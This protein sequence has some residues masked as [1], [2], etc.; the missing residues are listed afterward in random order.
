MDGSVRGAGGGKSAG[1]QAAPYEEPD[2]LHSIA[3]SHVLLAAGEGELGGL[4]NGLKSVYLDGTVLQNDDNTFNFLNVQVDSRVGT[5]NQDYIKGYPE[6]ESETA[7]G[8]ELKYGT[9][10]THAITDLDLSAISIRIST[11]TMTEVDTKTGDIY[12]TEIDFSFE[13]QTDGGS[14]IDIHDGYFQGKTTTDFQRDYRFDLPDATSGWVIRVT[15]TTPQST[16][17]SLTNQSFID[18]YTE[19][20]DAKL[21]Y[22]NTALLGILCDA[23]QFQSIPVI[24]ANWYGRIIRIPSNYN[25]YTRQYTGV[26][27]GTFV[28][29][30]TNNPAWH[31]YDICT[32]NRFGLGA[33]ITDDQVDKWSLYSIAQYC[34]GYVPTGVPKRAYVTTAGVFSATAPNLYKRGSGSFL[35]DGFQVGDEI[36][37]TGFVAAGNNGRGVITAVT[38]TQIT[39]GIDHV[40]TT[41]AA[42]GGCTIST[43]DF[44]E[45]RF[46]SALYLQAQDDAYKVLQDMASIFRG[47][48]YWAGGAIVPVCDQ[49]SDPVYTYANASVIGGKFTYSGSARKA[50]NTVA[51]VTWID[52]ANFYAATVEYVQLDDAV[53][54]F[55][56]RTTQITALGCTSRGMAQRVGR[57]LLLAEWLL[58]N[59]VSFSIGLE[60]TFCMPGQIVRV[61]DAKRAGRRIGGRIHKYADGEYVGIRYTE[62]GSIRLTEDGDVRI[63]EGDGSSFDNI[64]VDMMPGVVPSPGDTLVIMQAS[65]AATTRTITAVA[66]KTI[67]F[68]PP[69]DAYPADDAIWAVESSTLATQLFR[70]V[71]VAE[72]DGIQFDIT[73]LQHDP[74]LYAQVEAGTI[75]Q[76]PPISALPSPVQLPVSAVNLTSFQRAA[77]TA[78]ETVVRAEWA[79]PA[80]A[81]SY[82]WQWQRNGGPWSPAQKQQATSCEITAAFAGSYTFRVTTI[83]SSG[84]QSGS[85]KSSPLVVSLVTLPPLNATPVQLVIDSNGVATPDLSGGNDQ[86]TLALDANAT[87]GAPINCPQSC[88]ILVTVIQG[89]GFVLGM[90]P[91]YQPAN[92]IPY[93]AT[94]TAGAQDIVG[95]T[96]SNAGASWTYKFDKQPV[97]SAGAAF[98]IA[99]SNYTPSGY[100]V[101]AGSPITVDAT[102][103]ATINGGVMPIVS[104]GWS[105]A[106][107]GSSLLTNTGVSPTCTLSRTAQRT[108][109][110]EHWRFRAVDSTGAVAM[111][112]ATFNITIDDGTGYHG[113]PGG[114]GH[115]PG[116]EVP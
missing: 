52:P 6:V 76:Q 13:L 69:L 16:S 23:T 61:A 58:T 54:R 116:G 113:S 8:V 102:S 10:W 94:A 91:C 48:S 55:G 22:P 89:G 29:G 60:G 4:V 110:T 92:N 57:Y 3:Y 72:G 30:W 78:S 103:V 28:T 90:D 114:G 77:A 24:S 35:T 14:F 42:I 65:G 87:L 84:K 26:W 44:T 74:T 59:T 40:L 93:S 51:L 73:A 105:Y 41:A 12:G 18:A 47:I 1:G 33:R 7:V 75:T 80:G 67:A 109:I 111:A 70:V 21:R 107:S 32:Q 31:Y 34:D 98:S 39:I 11:P 82:I 2:N 50:R 68:E 46:T 38:A 112:V 100:G 36:T 66:D 45:P 71:S 43:Q 115:G 88:T 96:T 95:A 104:S 79:P 63:I 99:L 85:V 19:I 101:S 25:P 20:V 56:V 27:D 83:G 53:A 64:F 15:R 86:F 17:V 108:N 5:Q 9:P 106:D 62:D 37:A 49:P 97:D 81:L